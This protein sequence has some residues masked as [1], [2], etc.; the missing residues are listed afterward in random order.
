MVQRLAW[1]VA[2]VTLGACSG[3]TGTATPDG[4]IHYDRAL[5]VLFFQEEG[6]DVGWYHTSNPIADQVFTELGHQR[7]W[8]T[9]T[10]KHSDGFFT[11]DQLLKFDVV[12]YLISSGTVLDAAERAAMQSYIT[13]YKHGYVG[14]HS[15]SFTDPDWQWYIGLVGDRFATE[16]PVFDTATVHVER[17]NEDVM[18][19]LPVDWVRTDQWYVFLTPPQNNPNLEI[20]AS[21]DE[22][23]LP[24]D[25]P[26]NLRIGYHPI[27]WRQEIDGAR[28]FYTGTGHTDTSYSEPLFVNM[29]ANAIAWAGEPSRTSTP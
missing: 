19:G 14:V 5:R 24:P 16:S 11:I 27:A 7:G 29:I 26:D 23:T 8:E 22:S 20:L 17:P 12:C 6:A 15:A 1:L 4:P 10:A 25:Y 18:A 13:D 3:P 21:L 2:A 9:L 28:S